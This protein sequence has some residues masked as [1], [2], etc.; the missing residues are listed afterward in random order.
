MSSKKRRFNGI[1]I[2][3]PRHPGG[4]ET[5]NNGSPARDPPKGCTKW[6]SYYE[7]F[8]RTNYSP[9]INSELLYSERT[10]F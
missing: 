9:T 1:F 8:F 5:K 6:V 3:K 10:C 4:L 2:F 7:T